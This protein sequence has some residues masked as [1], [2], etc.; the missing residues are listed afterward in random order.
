MI[1]VVDVMKLTPA[2]LLANSPFTFD[3]NTGTVTDEDAEGDALVK[4]RG[5]HNVWD[6]DWSR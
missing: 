1:P 6:D 5:T 4:E 3:D 2:T